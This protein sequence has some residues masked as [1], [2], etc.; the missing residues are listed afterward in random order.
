MT[1]PQLDALPALVRVAHNCLLAP[2]SPP[3]LRDSCQL[4]EYQAGGV[5]WLCSLHAAGLSGILADE[6]GLGKNIH[7]IFIYA[8]MNEMMMATNLG[9]LQFP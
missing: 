8:R 5:E 9:V 4:R 6:M 3:L 2:S 7:V 1:C